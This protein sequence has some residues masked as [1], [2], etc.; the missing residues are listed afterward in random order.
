MPKF[1]LIQNKPK[2]LSMLVHALMLERQRA[3]RISRVGRIQSSGAMRVDSHTYDCLIYCSARD[4]TLGSMSMIHALIHRC[5]SSL[6][7]LIRMSLNFARGP[8]CRLVS[9]CLKKGVSERY[10]GAC[11]CEHVLKIRSGGRVSPCCIVKRCF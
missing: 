6:H 2:L 7:L 1:H 9:C 3:G 5:S 10:A 4:H 8:G 11:E